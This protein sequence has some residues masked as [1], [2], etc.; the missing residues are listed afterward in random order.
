[1]PEFRMGDNVLDCIHDFSD[2]SL[3]VSSQKGCSIGSDDGLTFIVEKFR[4]IRHFQG[5]AVNSLQRN[6]RAV[7]IFDYLR[8]DSATGSIR[9]RIDMCNETYGRNILATI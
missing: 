5:E 3:V 6:V 1:M 4:K 2:S 7:I 8:F 9:R